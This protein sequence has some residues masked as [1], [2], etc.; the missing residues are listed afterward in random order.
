MVISAAL[1]SEVTGKE[2]SASR[3]HT[4]LLVKEVN[5]EDIVALCSWMR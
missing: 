1:R 3:G 2:V 5:P 4:E